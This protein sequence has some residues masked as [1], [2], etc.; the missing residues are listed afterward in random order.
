MPALQFLRPDWPIAKTAQQVENQVLDRARTTTVDHRR[1][2]QTL[3]DELGSARFSERRAAQQQLR[4]IGQPV[5]VFLRQ[6]DKDTLDAE[7]CR[8]VRELTRALATTTADTPTR[9]AAW[10]VDDRD[11]WMILLSRNDARVRSV[12][13]RHLSR[14]LGEP[15]DFDPDATAD[16][17]REQIARLQTSLTKN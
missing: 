9:V 2:W 10:M 16:T 8:R 1:H 17:R 6:L 15:I 12:A 4:R 11:A 14:V 5:A 3:V 7:Q 13:A